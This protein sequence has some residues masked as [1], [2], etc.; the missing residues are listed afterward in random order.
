MRFRRVRMD[1][2][3]SLGFIAYELR[4]DGRVAYAAETISREFARGI[5]HKHGLATWRTFVHNLRDTLEAEARSVS[6]QTIPS[7]YDFMEFQRTPRHSSEW[8]RM[9]GLT[10]DG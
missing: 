9:M 7:E 5:I 8:D 3:L 2:T 4:G 10:A 6:A 1:N